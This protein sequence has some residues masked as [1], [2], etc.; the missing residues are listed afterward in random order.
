MEALRVQY[1]HVSRVAERDER[2]LAL[3]RIDQ[4]R[5]EHLENGQRRQQHPEYETAR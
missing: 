5:F 1:G 3:V 4:G 2:V